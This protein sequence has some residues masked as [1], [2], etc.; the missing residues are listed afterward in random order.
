MPAAAMRLRDA[1]I[2]A[3]KTGNVAGIVEKVDAVRRAVGADLDIMVDLHGPPWMT[4]KDAIITGKALEPYDLMFFEEPVAPENLDALEQ[5]RTAVDIPIAAGERRGDLWALR[6]LI[7]RHLVDVV[8]PDTGRTGISQIRKVAAMAEAHYIM[9]A[10]HSGTLGPVA[11][12]AALHLL[13]ALSNGLM[14][15]RLENDWSGRYEVV[16]PVLETDNGFIRVPDGP[17]LGVD[18]VE[19]EIVKYPSER[20]CGVPGNPEGGAYAAGTFDEN[21][22]VQPRFRRFG[23]FRP[24]QS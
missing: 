15:E 16:T 17:G 14:L 18:L 10:P 20:N 13:A 23:A 8:Q 22:Y 19:E 11:E 3:V 4:V 9:V 12:F 24:K 7:E 2:T 5:V 1:G 6:P 21:V